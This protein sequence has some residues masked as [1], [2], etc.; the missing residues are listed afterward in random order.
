MSHLV[1]MCLNEKCLD[2]KKV[3]KKGICPLY[4]TKAKEYTSWL[5]EVEARALKR[6]ADLKCSVSQVF[7]EL[8]FNE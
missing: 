5:G 3:E 7:L 1:W 2:M 8:T 4:S 6:L